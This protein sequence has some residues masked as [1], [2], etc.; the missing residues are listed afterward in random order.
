[1]DRILKNICVD[2]LPE[3]YNDMARIIGTENLIKLIEEFGGT[4]IYLP[5]KDKLMKQYKYQAI[6]K[7]FNGSNKRELS[8]KYDISESTIYR[9]IKQANRV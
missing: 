1:M 5:H 8:K 9:I 3:P 2:E 6:L 7:E 4:Q